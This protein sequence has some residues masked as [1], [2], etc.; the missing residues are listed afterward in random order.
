MTSLNTWSPMTGVGSRIYRLVSCSK[1]RS[2]NSGFAGCSSGP[3]QECF[4]CDHV[5]CIH[6]LFQPG[7]VHATLPHECYALWWQTVHVYFNRLLYHWTSFFVHC[8]FSEL[9]LLIYWCRC[10]VKG[11]YL[12]DSLFVSVLPCLTM[13]HKYTWYICRNI[14]SV[15]SWRSFAQ[16]LLGEDGNGHTSIAG[17]DCFNGGIFE[18]IHV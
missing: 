2:P 12:G 17:F 9:L 10:Q 8:H 6:N 13:G 11:Q 4:H 16:W 3:W 15:S 14:S 5:Y 18:F 7:Q 1:L